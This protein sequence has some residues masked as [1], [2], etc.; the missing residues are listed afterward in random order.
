MGDLIMTTP[1]MRALKETFPQARLSLLT[2]PAGAII[3]GL[4]P[5]VDET[6]VYKA[7]WMKL[8]ELLESRDDRRMIEYLRGFHFDAAVIFTVYSQ[9]PLP[10]ALLCYLAEIPLRLAHCRENP[11]E[12]LSHWIPEKEPSLER[13]EVRR[14]LDLVAAIGAET[15][16]EQ[17]GLSVPDAAYRSI[18]RRLKRL[19]VDDGRLLAVVHPGASAPSRRY[20][21]E[22]Y[23]R[24]L[25]ILLNRW[26]LDVIFTGLPSE[27]ELIRSIQKIIPFPTHSLAGELDCE[28]LAA[29]IDSAN[30]LISNN[31]GPAH[32]AAATN[33]P[34]VDL[35]ALTNPQ[36]TPW[37][38]PHR[39]L[40]YDVPCK[41]CY[42]SICPEKHHDCLRRVTPEEVAFAAEELLSGRMIQ[43]GEE[44]V[45]AGH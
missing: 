26:S 21:A 2:S 14:Q 28:E 43:E 8:N 45:Y 33:T 7:P 29:L 15:E 34:L 42:K 9:S 32:I 18:S 16:Q 38:V 19:N 27:V 24:A 11:Y 13:H 12:L 1:A 5:E 36:H 23:G 22:S 40:F 37:Q 20:P 6:I 10:A 3:S 31:T 17:L 41:Y 25:S 35:Y 4:I 39:V 30:V 44:N